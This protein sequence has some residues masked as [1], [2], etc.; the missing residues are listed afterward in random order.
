MIDLPIAIA[1][2]SFSAPITAAIVKFVPKKGGDSGKY[3]T[4]REYAAATRV[5][6]DRFD[7]LKE[8]IRELSGYVKSRI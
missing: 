5:M 7:E 6:H 8:D 3:V 4:Y 2:L 1:F